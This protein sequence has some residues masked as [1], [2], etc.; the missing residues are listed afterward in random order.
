MICIYED[1]DVVE[2]NA[3]HWKVINVNRNNTLD[4]RNTAGRMVDD[5]PIDQVKPA[6]STIHGATFR[7]W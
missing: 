1:Y 7:T 6:S 3:Q 2:W 5:V 4:L